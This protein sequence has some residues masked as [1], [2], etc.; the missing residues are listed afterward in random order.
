MT[1]NITQLTATKSKASEIY[2]LESPEVSKAVVDAV[3]AQGAANDKWVYS[4][5]LLFAADVR[6]DDLAKTAA[7]KIKV[8]VSAMILAALPPVERKAFNL[9]KVGRTADDV[10]HASSATRKITKYLGTIA[11][12]LRKMQDDKDGKTKPVSFG[13]SLANQVQELIDKIARAPEKKINF[14]ASEAVLALKK[15]KAIFQKK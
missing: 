8:A 5:S 1:I 2:T 9:P 11:D 14:D 13:E 3:V 7:N 12:Y 6:A 4:A 15:A 10:S